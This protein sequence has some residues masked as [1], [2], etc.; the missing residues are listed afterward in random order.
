MFSIGWHYPVSRFRVRSD[1]APGSPAQVYIQVPPGCG[2]NLPVMVYRANAQT[3]GPA[4]SQM[5]FFSYAPPMVTCIG[6]P[7]VDSTSAGCARIYVDGQNFGAA[8]NGSMVVVRV[9]GPNNA[10]HGVCDDVQYVAGADYVRFSCRLPSTA[11]GGDQIIVTNE[12]GVSSAL[13]TATI[14]TSIIL[15]N[16]LSNFAVGKSME[17]NSAVQ[18]PIQPAT[19]VRQESEITVIIK[20]GGTWGDRVL[21][22]GLFIG[23]VLPLLIIFIV[24]YV[25]WVRMDAGKSRAGG[26][27]RVGTGPAM[28]APAA[29]RTVASAPVQTTM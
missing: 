23:L 19:S 6:Q 21:S 16:Q 1:E 24:G 15:T 10:D 26:S 3:M 27:G 11:V 28:F 4:S 29:A 14:P 25:L 2:A 13:S 8:T 12:C 5:A 9:V 20:Q 18:A 17:Y 7:F 22:N